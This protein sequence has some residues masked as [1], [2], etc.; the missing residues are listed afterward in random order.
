MPKRTAPNN[1]NN[2]ND[3]DK[4]NNNMALSHIQ[5]EQ[6]TKALSL[7]VKGRFKPTTQVVAQPAK[8]EE[9]LQLEAETIAKMTARFQT[10]VTTWNFGV[11]RLTD[12]IDATEQDQL[13]LKNLGKASAMFDQFC[14]AFSVNPARNRLYVALQRTDA[15]EQSKLP[16]VDTVTAVMDELAINS[17]SSSFYVYMEHDD[18]TVTWC[19]FGSP[20]PVE[21][22]GDDNEYCYDLLDPYDGGFALVYKYSACFCM[23]SDSIED[24]T[25]GVGVRID[26]DLKTRHQLSIPHRELPM[27]DLVSQVGQYYRSL[28]TARTVNFVDDKERVKRRA[29]KK[30]AKKVASKARRR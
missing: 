22:S 30:A 10:P 26:G 15:T 12:T 1:N 2:N 9:E 27:Q 16:E 11:S 7:K 13:H 20:D 28:Q 23:V 5:R 24:M 18:G 21:L 25:K 17:R 14:V 3:R 4:V 19:D 6:F 29:K 8:S